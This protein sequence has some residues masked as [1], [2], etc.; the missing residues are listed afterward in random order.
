MK[1]VVSQKDVELLPGYPKQLL[2]FG[3]S[4]E[5]FVDPKHA[6]ECLPENDTYRIKGKDRDVLFVYDFSKGIYIIQGHEST[7]ERKSLGQFIKDKAL[8]DKVDKLF[9]DIKQYCNFN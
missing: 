7:L 4:V 5:I 3:G 9:R 8:C 2:L 6:I 1:K